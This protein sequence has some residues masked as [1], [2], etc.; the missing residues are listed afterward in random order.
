MNVYNKE[1]RSILEYAVPVWSPGLTSSDAKEIE[2]IQKSAFTI[3]F[4]QMSYETALKK[5]GVKTLEDRRSE[6]CKNF[7][8][9]TS[10]HSI[11]SQ[12]Y[13]KNQS[14]VNTRNR[15]QYCEVTCRTKAWYN[16]PIPTMTRTL[17][18]N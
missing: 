16:S 8:V 4:G 2:R 13:Q 3:I 15:K 9:K 5:H 12:W 6:L 17:N 7:A 14:N 10:K 1:I 11:F 18:S